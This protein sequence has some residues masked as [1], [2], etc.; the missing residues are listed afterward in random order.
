MLRHSLRGLK[1][2]SKMFK[3]SKKSAF[4]KWTGKLSFKEF[5]FLMNKHQKLELQLAQENFDNCQIQIL[6][7]RIICYKR[8]KTEIV[9]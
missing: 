7:N 3:V 2:I 6:D 4:T 9:Q 5:M 1:Q 8:K